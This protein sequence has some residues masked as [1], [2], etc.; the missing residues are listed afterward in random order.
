MPGYHALMCMPNPLVLSHNLPVW[1]CCCG[2]ANESLRTAAAQEAGRDLFALFWMNVAKRYLCSSL[3]SP[4][5]NRLIILLP[6][7]G[8]VKIH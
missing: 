4:A 7:S 6:L 1:L 8:G 3:F 5:A 2:S